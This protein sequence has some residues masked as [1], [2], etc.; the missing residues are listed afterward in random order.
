[1]NEV[2]DK[3]EAKHDDMDEDEFSR[4]EEEEPMTREQL[5]E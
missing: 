2:D 1:M 3:E 5:E 4:D